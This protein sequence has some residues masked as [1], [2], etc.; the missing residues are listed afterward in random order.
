[1]LRTAKI[2]SSNFS[3]KGIAISVKKRNDFLALES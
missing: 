2:E 1:M 3:Q